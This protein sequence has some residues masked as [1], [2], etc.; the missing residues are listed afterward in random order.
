[1]R[2]RMNGVT[3]EAFT[4]AQCDALFSAILIN[5]EIDLTAPLPPVV[6]FRYDQAE[7]AR[8]FAICRLIWM[9]HIDREDCLRIAS[10]LRR[11]RQIDEAEQLRFKHIRARFKHLRFAFAAFDERHRYPILLDL[12]TSVMGNLQDAFKNGKFASAQRNA[13]AWKWLLSR[14]LFALL[15]A[16]TGRFRPSSSATF[17]AYMQGQMRPVFAFLELPEVTAKQFHDIRKIISRFRAC[18]ATISVMQPSDYH[19]QI[20][21]YL[22]T[23]NGMMGS[24]HDGLMA[25]KLD[26][27]LDYHRDR[28]VLQSEIARRL[29]TLATAVTAS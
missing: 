8:Y 22:A 27:R 16:E 13:W 7:L 21:V 2:G 24:F 25:G 10:L 23:I 4:Q 20:A 18:F 17:A 6:H 5:D 11:D 3:S 26:G 14:P 15:R 28:F 9:T 29:R 12:M 19:Q 1:M